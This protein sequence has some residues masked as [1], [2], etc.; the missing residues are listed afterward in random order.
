MIWNCVVYSC[1]LTTRR[2]LL[3]AHL[4]PLG[5][6]L[7]EPPRDR[8][9]GQAAAAVL[10]ASKTTSHSFISPPNALGWTQKNSL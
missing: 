9:V 8:L 1:T 3:I 5:D 6:R 7:M 2:T 10:L 4:E